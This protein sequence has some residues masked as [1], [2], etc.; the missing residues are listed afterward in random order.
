[1]SELLRSATKR[2][3]SLVD[4]EDSETD[5][6]SKPIYNS[7]YSDKNNADADLVI[8]TNDNVLFRVHSYYLKAHRS[9][10]TDSAPES[11]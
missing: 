4:P 8:Q 5:E 9:A 10:L 7:A 11:C 2:P 1:M 3:I 6:A